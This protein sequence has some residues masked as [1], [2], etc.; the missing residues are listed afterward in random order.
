MKPFT[1]ILTL[2]VLL[3]T[4]CI[5]AVNP[6]TAASVDL[7]KTGLVLASMRLSGEA[8]D[9]KKVAVEFYLRPLEGRGS[10]MKEL[11][12]NSSRDLWLIEVPLGSYRIGD[13]FLGAG[14]MRRESGEHSFEFD[15]RP[16]EITYIGL[17]D[18][19]VERE[20]N[21]FG[22]RVIPLASPVLRDDYIH[23]VSAFKEKFP[24]LSGTPIRNASP[25]K[26][27]WG[28]PDSMAVPIYIPVQNTK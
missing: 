3:L 5:T 9:V 24:S 4:G 6:E 14:T 19:A 17:F 21:T 1:A 27:D 10:F 25:A 12:I 20:K 15:V 13:W 18:V 28:T 22:L 26:F 8:D 7:T 2:S 16:G 23:T 11:V